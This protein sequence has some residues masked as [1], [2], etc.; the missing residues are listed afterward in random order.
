MRI[1]Q[2]RL[3]KIINEEIKNVSNEVLTEGVIEDYG[4]QA[5]Q[6][7]IGAAAE[8]G[9]GALT[10]PAAGAGLAVGPAAN[11][12]VDAAFGMSAISGVIGTI[13]SLSSQAGELSGLIDGIKSASGLISKD[14]DAFY[15]S[16]KKTVEK[17][18]GYSG[19]AIGPAVIAQAA[20]IKVFLKKMIQSLIDPITK[21]INFIVPDAVVGSS[22][23]AAITMALKQLATR[24]FDVA[25]SAVNALLDAISKF[26]TDPTVAPAFFKEMIPSI[27]KLLQEFAAK[28]EEMGWVKTAA[29]IALTGPTGIALKTVGPSGL[30]LMADKLQQNAGEIVNAAKII[31]S[32]V[33]PTVFG[34]LAAWQVIMT[35]GFILDNDKKEAQ[36]SGDNADSDNAQAAKTEGMRRKTILRNESSSSKISESTLRQLIREEL[37]MEEKAKKQKHH[38]NR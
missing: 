5:L 29:M 24:S 31:S 4:S 7:A 32:T 13:S 21:G 18:I 27:I 35:Q 12:A 20:K 8:Y 25:I 6:F 11:T 1:S 14:P 23:S 16:I 19:G 33:I 37:A 26:I 9:I 17:I 36:A 38:R 30:K 22:L 34:I 10:M 15:Q 2:S 28:I 3:H